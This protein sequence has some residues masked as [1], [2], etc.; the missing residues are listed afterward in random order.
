MICDNA[1]DPVL[2]LVEL[3]VLHLLPNKRDDEQADRHTQRQAEDVYEG[4]AFV[5]FEI[6][7]GDF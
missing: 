1:Y 3:V 2:M 7:E 6:A 4:I 5:P